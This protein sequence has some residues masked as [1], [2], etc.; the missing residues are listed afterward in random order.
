MQASSETQYMYVLFTNTGTW[1][2]RLIRLYTRQELNHV[3]ICL[4]RS[5][6]EVYSFGRKRPNNPFIGGFVKEDLQSSLFEQADCAIYRCPVN[7]KQYAKAKAT[8]R[9]FERRSACF[10][11]NLLGLIGV[12]LNK[13]IR[14]KCA[15]FCSQFVATIF[16]RLDH[17]LTTKC[18]AL[19]SPCDL[20]QSDKLECVYRGS[21]QEA[22]TLLGSTKLSEA[23]YR[24]ACLFHDEQALAACTN[25]SPCQ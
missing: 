6:S 10:R 13:P 22:Q 19:A 7:R 23:P 5:L 9:Q 1:F 2:T 15:Y 20:E 25:E 4:D 3:S 14:R 18:A 24:L 12:M 21:L 8:L 11:Y 17:P 16:E